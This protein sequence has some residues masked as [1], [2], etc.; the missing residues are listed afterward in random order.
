MSHRVGERCIVLKKDS[1]TVDD[2]TI[3]QEKVISF[4]LI[5]LI[6]YSF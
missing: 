4:V 2:T 1:E 6:I 3:S 5:I